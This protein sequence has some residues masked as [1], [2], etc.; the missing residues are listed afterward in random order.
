[1][2]DGYQAVLGSERRGHGRWIRVWTLGYAV[3]AVDGRHQW[4]L[5]RD[6]VFGSTEVSG[7]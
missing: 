6:V 5:R 3:A 2:K 1:M 7:V 4:G